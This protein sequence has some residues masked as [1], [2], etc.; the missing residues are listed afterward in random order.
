[1]MNYIL[2]GSFLLCSLMLYLFWYNIKHKAKK[3]DSLL[4]KKAIFNFNQQLMYRRL[5]EALPQSNILAQVSFDALVT[6]KYPRTRLK[7]RNLTAD[8]VVMNEEHRIVAIVVLD[9]LNILKR[10][11]QAMDKDTLLRMAGYNVI[12][13][14][15]IPQYDEL[16]TDLQACSASLKA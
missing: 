7:Y 2:I 10:A 1:M 9:E 14:S 15:G 12:R 4:K 13:Y 8:F 3:Q 6:T 11:Q 16:H 5:R